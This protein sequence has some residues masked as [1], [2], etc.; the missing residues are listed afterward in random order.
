[1]LW[2]SDDDTGV[3]MKFCDS[4]G[5]VYV[6]TYGDGVYVACSGEWSNYSADSADE[7]MSWCEY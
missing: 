7:S 1:M 5:A 4:M 6:L 3:C 2:V